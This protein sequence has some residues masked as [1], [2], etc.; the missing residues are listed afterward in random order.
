MACRVICI[1]RFLGAGGEEIGRS[2][3][4]KLGFRYVDDE[5]I[6]RA[7][8][9]AG[10]DPETVEQVEHAPGLAL[11]ILAGTAKL[12][13]DVQP[14]TAYLALLAET[15]P[16]YQQLIEQVIRETANA[17]DVVI[18]AHSASIPLAGM[19]GLLRALVTGTPARRAGRLAREAGLGE[20]EAKKA[21]QDSDRQRR[22]YL[23]RFYA[24]HQELPLHYDLVVNTDA[25]APAPAAQVVLAAANAV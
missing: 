6:A 21:I 7:A 24:V 23:R 20:R 14:W 5:I 8:E 12:V 9:K 15:S 4:G 16:S 17:G 19:N 13:A 1:S 10:V 3:A 2:V 11:R 22:D 25:L 18:V